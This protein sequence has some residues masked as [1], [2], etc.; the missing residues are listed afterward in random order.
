[1]LWEGAKEGFFLSLPVWGSYENSW[2]RTYL[3]SFLSMCTP[4]NPFLHQCVRVSL[5]CGSQPWA[6]GPLTPRTALA[7]QPC[8]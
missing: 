3:S 7:R 6:W 5:L 4:G 2:L 8:C 1:M